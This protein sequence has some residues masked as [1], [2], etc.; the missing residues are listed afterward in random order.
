[1]GAT[2]PAGS[3]VAEGV[4]AGDNTGAAA[5]AVDLLLSPL[6]AAAAPHPDHPRTHLQNA[7][8]RP[9]QFPNMIRYGCLIKVGEPESLRE[10]LD[11]DDWKQA[12]DVEYEALV[13]NSTWHLVPASE[14]T[15]VIDSKWVYKIK[16][17]AD[18]TVDCSKARLVAKGFKQRYGIDY[19]ETFS[20]VVKAATIRMVL[21]IGVSRGWCF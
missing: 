14:A 7:I 1:M 9:K 15:N 21:S 8:S 18:G 19:E 10:A 17:K 12:M 6:P 5:V 16:R 3:S 13:R 2:S 4:A 11:N 20:P